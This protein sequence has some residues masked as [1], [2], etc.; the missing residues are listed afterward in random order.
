ME[1]VK[2][3]EKEVF[4]GAIRDDLP[5]SFDS[6]TQWPKCIHEIRDQQQCGSCWAFAASEVLSD[7]F[8]IASQ[9]STDVIMSPQEL[10]SCD[11]QDYGCNGGYVDKSW[12]YIRDTGIVSDGCLPYT[13]GGG[14]SG[15][16]PFNSNNSCEDGSPF[17]R[18]QVSAHGQL[19]TIQDAKAD[20]A[21]NGPVEAAFDVYDDFMSYQG[22]V[23]R[24][25]SDNLLG[26]H[27]VKIVGWGVDADGTEYWI[28]ANSWNTS[29]GEN[30]FFRIAFGECNFEQSLWAGA[31]QL[32]HSLMFLSFDH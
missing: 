8:C 31:P 7:R 13:S 24:R 3:S 25:Q 26:G 29:W 22:G 2:K 5:K 28:V 32:K 15:S 12:D 20:I 9:S 16:C 1:P 4:Y 17:K 23:Y 18:Y 21:A 11:T 14:D 30:G 27:A 19:T 10:V 6:R